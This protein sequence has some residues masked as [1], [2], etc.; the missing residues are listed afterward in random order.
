MSLLTEFREFAVKGNAVDMAVGIIVGTAFNKIVNSIVTDLVMPP[1]GLA[2]GG[3]NFKD[4]KWVLQEKKV[5]AAGTEVSEVAIAYGQFFDTL[6][7]FLIISFT[8]FMVV[9]VMNH[10]LRDRAKKAEEIAAES[11]KL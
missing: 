9:K 1:I 2:I 11:K 7:Q 8:V 5:D 6:I 10:L 4:L 3:V